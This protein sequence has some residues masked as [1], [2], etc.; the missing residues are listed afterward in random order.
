MRSTVTVQFP[1]KKMIN[2]NNFQLKVTEPDFF[3]NGGSIKKN[4]YQCQFALA[5]RI[6]DSILVGNNLDLF[7]FKTKN[8]ILFS[9]LF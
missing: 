3:W 2:I 1:R 6:L 7:S 8:F 9:S 4:Q 5:G